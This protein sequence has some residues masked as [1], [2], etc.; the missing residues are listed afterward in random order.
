MG[1]QIGGRWS[2]KSFTRGEIG[3]SLQYVNGEPAAVFYPTLRHEEGW[4]AYVMSLDGLYRYREDQFLL[5]AA[6]RAAAVMG[7]D[8]QSSVTAA[9]TKFMNDMII[10]VLNM[11]PLPAEAEDKITI[12][13]INIDDDG[14]RVKLEVSH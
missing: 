3:C 2:R 14:R 5:G 4:G 9:M 12:D 7:F 11:P 10:E 13:D 6:A 1:I 8:P